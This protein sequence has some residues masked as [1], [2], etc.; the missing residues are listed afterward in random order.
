MDFA[1]MNQKARQKATS[2]V[3]RDF[4]KLLNKSSFAIDCRFNID[5]C[6]FEPLYNDLAEISY[7]K[8]FTTIF[9][10]NTFRNYFS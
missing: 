3:E 8:H 6:I 9:S 10:D 7:I 2:S 5:N 1:I 4:F